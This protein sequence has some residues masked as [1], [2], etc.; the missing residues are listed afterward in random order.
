[1]APDRI[2]DLLLLLGHH[3]HLPAEGDGVEPG[4]VAAHHPAHFLSGADVA[5][6]CTKLE[7]L[8]K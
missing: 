1:L 8:I 3:R 2:P 7:R 6:F 5:K 4:T